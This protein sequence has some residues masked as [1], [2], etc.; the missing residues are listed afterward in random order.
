MMLLYI[1]VIM[2]EDM[3]FLEACALGK[4]N[5]RFLTG[6]QVVKSGIDSM[7]DAMKIA[8]CFGEDFG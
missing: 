1:L 5:G 6:Y 2:V 3:F 8:C 4:I 7:P